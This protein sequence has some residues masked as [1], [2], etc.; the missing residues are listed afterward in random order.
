[1]K[2]PFA[3]LMFVSASALAGAA[4]SEI[5]QKKQKV[6][7]M[8]ATEARGNPD[9]AG[10]AITEEGGDNQHAD[11]PKGKGKSRLKAPSGDC[12]ASAETHKQGH[13]HH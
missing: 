4:F 2:K 9:P 3:I 1:M 13:S 12:P 6:P 5:P 11:R 10:I 7:G 8:C